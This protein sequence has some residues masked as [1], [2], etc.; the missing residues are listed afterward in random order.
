MASKLIVL[1]D[2]C[3][4]YPNYLRD[5]LIQLATTDLFRAKS[6]KPSKRSETDSKNHQSALRTILQS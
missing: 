3:V 1:Y 2:A 4:L 6:L 5:L